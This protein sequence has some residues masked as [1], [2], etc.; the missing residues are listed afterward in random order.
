LEGRP[1]LRTLKLVWNR[2]ALFSPAT[3]AFLRFLAAVLPAL[4]G[5]ELD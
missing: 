3:R 5:L 1:L 2:N 4:H